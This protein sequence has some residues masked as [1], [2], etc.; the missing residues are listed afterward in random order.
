MEQV[1]LLNYNCEPLHL[2][3]WK[4]TIVL[5]LK[6]KAECMEGLN[7]LEHYIKKDNVYIPKVIRL[8]YETAIPDMGLPYSRENILKRDDYTC[9][10]C[11]KKLSYNEITL[12]H[13]F[14]KSRFGPDSWENIVVCC[15]DCNQYK[16][17]RTPK[18]AGMKLRRRP[19]PP[20]DGK[21]FE[22]TKNSSKNIE[23]WKSFYKQNNNS[24]C[25]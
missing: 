15:K 5:L 6:G 14:P 17:N 7:K 20:K 23:L 21:I 10:Y 13:V 19:E 22:L 24:D 11:G 3:T 12:D 1:L 2:T 18:E 8:K 25:A 16:A 9:Q 4:H